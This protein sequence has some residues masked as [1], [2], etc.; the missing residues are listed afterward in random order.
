MNFYHVV[1]R[2]CDRVGA[3]SGLP[4]PYGL[5]KDEIVRACFRSLLVALKDFPHRITVLGDSLSEENRR[6]FTEHDVDLQEGTFGNGPSFRRC[7][8][9]AMDGPP[10]DWVYLLEDDYL[11]VP[12]AFSAI[13]ALLNERKEVL[14]FRPRSRLARLLR[15]RQW[16]RGLEERPLVIFPP[17]YPDRYALYE[18]EP[19][20]VFLS[21]RSHWRQVANTT[22]TLLTQRRTIVQHQDLLMRV[23]AGADD[24]MLSRE[25]YG[26]EGFRERALCLSPLP[27]LTTHLHEGTATPLVD[28]E[29]VLRPY[30]DDPSRDDPA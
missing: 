17:D 13:D 15:R 22:L 10:D 5:E 16:Q 25:L 1:L 21:S 20:I 2:A 28:W 19:W 12:H 26:R 7:V 29:A 14:S 24:A 8:E 23:S 3:A 30:L 11:H 27:G 18:R 6:F 4:R 9:I